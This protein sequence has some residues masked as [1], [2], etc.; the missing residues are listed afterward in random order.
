MTSAV[1]VKGYLVTGTD[2]GIG[3]TVVSAM[4]ARALNAVYFKPVQAGLD[5]ETDTE[6]VRRLSGLPDAHFLPET[7][8]LTTPASPHLSAAIDEIEIEVG[9]LLVPETTKPIIVE[10]AGGVMVPLTETTLCIDIFESWQ[11]PAIVCART[12]LG[13][14]NH[15]LMTINALRQWHVTV[16]G[17]VFIGDEHKENQTIIPR[18]GNVTNLGRLPHL[19]P[20]NADTLANAF[21]QNF[22]LEQFTR[23]A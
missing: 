8:R 3:K 12:S 14:I 5:E 10:G 1:N 11:L 15:T 9:K 19:D 7:Y 20:L 23:Q 18:L 21:E 13:T 16:H 17:V 4:L 6:T 22:L 2:T